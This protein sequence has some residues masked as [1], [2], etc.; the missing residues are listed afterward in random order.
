MVYYDPLDQSPYYRSLHSSL[1]NTV[2]QL[3]NPDTAKMAI[4]TL[5]VDDTSNVLVSWN[6]PQSRTLMF[7]RSKDGGETWEPPQSIVS[8]D[9]TSASLTPGTPTIGTLGKSVFLFWHAEQKGVSCTQNY[10]YSADSGATWSDKKSLFIDLG[11]CPNQNQLLTGSNDRLL[12][13]SIFNNQVYATAWNGKDFVSSQSQNDLSSFT[14]PKSFNLVQMGCQQA[15][16]VL[17]DI[18]VIGCEKGGNQ[19]IWVTSR[20]ADSLFKPPAN[21]A[22]WSV[23]EVI[24]QGNSRY[25]TLTLLGDPRSTLVHAFWS[26]PDGTRAVDPGTSIY[27]SSWVQAQSIEPSSILSSTGGK[28]NQ[29][30]VALDTDGRFYLVWSGGK[31]GDLLFSWA[32]TDRAST[33]LDW[34]TPLK[35]PT[36]HPAAAG[37][38]IKVGADRVLYVAYLIPLN[39]DRGVYTVKSSDHGATWSSP[40]RVFDAAAEG[41]DMVSQLSMDVS[42]GQRGARELGLRHDPGRVGCIRLSLRQFG[43]WRAK[44]ERPAR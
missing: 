9:Q 2:V 10:A 3:I 25:E 24:T 26:Q 44:L 28:S 38:V 17:E 14:A 6:N 30:S 7:G 33:P 39:E 32:T 12:L 27:Y 29:P 16:W 11:L 43:R 37:P 19:D 5:A 40:V 22:V 31:S 15:A 23:P 13:F 36:S 41:C 1:T 4:R 21:V 42:S 8:P 20:S 35:I 18:Y 34:F